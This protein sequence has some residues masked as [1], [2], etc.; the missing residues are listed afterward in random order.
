MAVNAK[1]KQ[2]TSQR[3]TGLLPVSTRA[4]FAQGSCIEILTTNIWLEKF[5]MLY[6]TPKWQIKMKNTR[7]LLTIQEINTPR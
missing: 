5:G 6:S 4:S 7:F 2:Y 3:Q 1:V